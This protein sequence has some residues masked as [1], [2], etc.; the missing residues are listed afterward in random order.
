MLSILLI[1]SKTDPF[2]TG[3]YLYI[4]QTGTVICPVSA[5]L[6]YLTIR[7]PSPDPL[8]I[9]QDGTPLSRQQLVP[10][11]L[12]ALAGIGVDIAN[13]SATVIGSV[14]PLLQQGLIS[15]ILLIKHWGDESRQPSLPTLGPLS[16]TWWQLLLYS[17]ALLV[18]ST[19]LYLHICMLFSLLASLL[20]HFVLFDIIQ[21]SIHM[22]VLKK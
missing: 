1:R 6:A 19:D 7:S 9:F 11:L 15:A 10:H 3:T 14:H 8:F 20:I 4:G 12:N 21:Y 22:E 5:L 18:D 16:K 2:G 13:Y 17:P